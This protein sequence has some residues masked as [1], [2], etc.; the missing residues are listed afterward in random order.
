MT[1]SLSPLF[2]D[3]QK[4]RTSMRVHSDPVVGEPQRSP[5]EI[6]AYY[7]FNA[8]PKKKGFFAKLF[9][10]FKKEPEAPVIQAKPSGLRLSIRLD[11]WHLEDAIKVKSIAE[12]E[13]KLLEMAEVQMTFDAAQVCGNPTFVG[14]VMAA[15]A[16][17]INR[18]ANLIAARTRRGA[19]TTVLCHPVH[20]EALR[21]AS[22]SGFARNADGELKKD[23]KPK[24]GRWTFEGTLN[25]SM[26]VYSH[27]KMTK[28]KLVVAY[29]GSNAADAPGQL[30]KDEDGQLYLHILPNTETTL[31]NVK[32]YLQGVGFKA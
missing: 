19:G 13:D 11:K 20:V 22:T 29:V 9:S 4:Q 17:Q 3:I 14:D 5:A 25:G 12:A 26:K 18:C 6:A 16:I 21:A 1:K 30:F 28:D 15:L 23:K 31:G 27:S 2:V 7:G 24:V 8:E 32:D 10:V